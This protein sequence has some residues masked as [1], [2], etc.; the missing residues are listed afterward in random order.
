MARRVP[1]LRRLTKMDPPVIDPELA[2]EEQRVLV[3]G[4]IVTN[5]A[6]QVLPDARIVVKA[7][8]TLQ[9]VRKL[10]PALDH[11]GIDPTDAV[12][13][14][15]GACTGGFTQALLD[16]GA[17]HVFAIDVGHGQLLGS[18]RQDDRVVS[19]ERTNLATVTPDLLGGI[20]PAII[21]CDVTKLALREVGRQL[22]DNQVPK[23][24]T[25]FV[26]LVK[27]MFE[28]ATASLPIDP[29]ELRQAVELAAQGLSE[30]GW[31]IIG[32]MD[33]VVT[34]HRGA[35]EFF[36]HARWLQLPQQTAP[37]VLPPPRGSS[38]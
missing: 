38:E 17:A 36:I 29:D 37:P 13:V 15:L 1:L 6:S 27:P 22:A 28:L 35:V 31:D 14:D 24:G 5:P 34:G 25:D 20:H 12:A 9:G 3:D 19:L 16:R 18:L 33:S 26:G 30:V 7:P 11:F 10:T 8:T 23:P 32:W 21:V 2:L 4:V